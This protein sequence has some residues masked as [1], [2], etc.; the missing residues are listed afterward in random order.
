MN[1]A[2]AQHTW[3]ILCYHEVADTP[4]DP[5]DTAIHYPRSEL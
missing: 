1:E 2:V 3:L 5:G 4:A